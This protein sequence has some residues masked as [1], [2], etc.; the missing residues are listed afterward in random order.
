VLFLCGQVNPILGQASVNE[1]IKGS[2]GELPKANGRVHFGVAG[3][4]MDIQTG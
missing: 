2:E 3:Q 1:P 4:S